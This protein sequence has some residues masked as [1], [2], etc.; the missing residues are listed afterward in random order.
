M[1]TFAVICVVQELSAKGIAVAP[2]DHA[3]DAN[4]VD[5]VW[6]SRRPEPPQE[7]VRLHP[8]Q[9]AGETVQAKLEKVDKLSKS[10]C[11]NWAWV[12]RVLE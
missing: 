8:V 4:P 6:G 12:C 10:C 2:I 3:G 11:A 1:P 5:A 7:P 9:F